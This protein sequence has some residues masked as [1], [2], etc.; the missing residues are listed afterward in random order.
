MD[1][2]NPADDFAGLG[3]ARHH[4]VNATAAG[5]PIEICARTGGAGPPLLLLHG[6]P[7]THAMWRR[8]AERLAPHY[9][10]VCADLRGYG[11]STKPADAP[12]HAELS[13][14]AMAADMRAL[15]RSLG[16]ERFG[17]L[18]HDRGARVAHRLALDAPEAVTRLLLIDIVPTLDMYER[19]DRAFAT[20]YY[21]WF[22]LIQ[23]VPLPERMIAGDW[24]F[25]LHRKLAGWGTG[26]LAPFEPAALAEYERAFSDPATV[27]AMCEDYRASAG[28]DL[29]H[30][31]AARAAGAKIACPL[32]VLWGERGVIHRLYEP[33]A[34]W[35]AQCDGPVT[36]RTLPAGHY[37]AEELPQETADEARA[38]FAP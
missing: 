16:H 13:K 4:R 5:A 30:D 37:L 3:A 26:G 17:V 6:F 28:I 9:T 34:L 12:G 11:G 32:H 22:H 19:A 23:P 15:M 33:L 21:H 14:R 36:G 8:V 10:L 24:R 1:A 18:A 2:G 7:Q 35:R 29:E 25:Y 27:H 20:A 38:F 31:R